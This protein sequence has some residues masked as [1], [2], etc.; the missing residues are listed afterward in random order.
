[1]TRSQTDRIT[2]YYD[3]NTHRFLRLGGGGD[4]G[5]IHRPIWAPEV[6]TNREAFEY[7]NNLTAEAVRPALSL[8]SDPHLLDLGCGVGGT[9]TYLAQ[10]LN[11]KVTGFTLSRVQLDLARERAARLGL[12][13][14]CLFLEADFQDL[15][16]V[17]P[18]CAAYA[19][20][21]F[22][23][24]ADGQR[25][26]DK[27]AAQ[28]VPHGRFALCDDFLEEGVFILPSDHPARVA[29]RRFTS[30]WH[31]PGLAMVVQARRMA[32]SAGLRMVES[33]DLT[34]HIRFFHPVVLRLVYELTRLPLPGSYWQN[35]SGGSALQMC[36]RSGWTR[37]H[38]LV[39]EKE[40]PCTP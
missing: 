8:L 19:I 25:F 14:R 23:H 39:F 10:R 3:R 36:I 31:I 1:M 27:A 18:A 2:R 33:C 28:L 11:V 22:V 16:Q 30:G 37:Y 26:F 20:E 7:L 21:S 29:L 24:A 5:A 4:A 13:D 34:A 32:E 35:L 38:L 9:A 15:P 12:S 17:E 6:R 40:G